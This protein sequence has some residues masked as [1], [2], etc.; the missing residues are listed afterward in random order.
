[1]RRDGPTCVVTGRRFSRSRFD[2]KVTSN[3]A[4]IIPNSVHRSVSRVLFTI[5]RFKVI[6][7]SA[8]LEAIAMFAGESA[9]DAVLQQLNSLENVLNLEGNAHE[10]YDSC[11]WGIEA[12]EIDGKVRRIVLCVP[13]KS[14]PHTP[15]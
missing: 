5:M 15:R 12:C 8:T 11:Q 4:H 13:F 1:M 2:G 6:F 10:F 9:R 7:Q 3:L 14:H